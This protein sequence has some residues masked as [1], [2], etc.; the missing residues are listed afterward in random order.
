MGS[1]KSWQSLAVGIIVF[2]TQGGAVSADSETSFRYFNFG[3]EYVEV[4]KTA[5]SSGLD[6]AAHLF[7]ESIVARN[8]DL[9]ER[10]LGRVDVNRLKKHLK[11]D[12]PSLARTIDVLS[13]A[14]RETISRHWKAFSTLFPDIDGDRLSIYTIP[15]LGM[16]EAQSRPV[17]DNYVIMLGVDEIANRARGK[18]DSVLLHHELFHIYH[19]QTNPFVNGGAKGFFERGELPAVYLLLWVEGL[20]T[21]AS[22]TLNSDATNSRIY[23]SDSLFDETES[24]MPFLLKR[25][26]DTLESNSIEDIAGFF[27]FASEDERIPKDCGYVIGEQLVLEVAKRHSLNEMAAMQESALLEEARHALQ[28]LIRKN[29]GPR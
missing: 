1:L 29:G 18:I 2:L 19:Y 6:E 26:S 28:I 8:R 25:L 3:D 16:F 7:H 9:Y 12:A 14:G 5:D 10:L 27:Y 21:F 20:A 17:G 24:R 23:F 13:D 22:R 4:L 15:S 11:D